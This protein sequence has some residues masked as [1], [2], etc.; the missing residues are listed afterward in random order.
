MVGVI[1][2]IV[3]VGIA[4]A[5]MYGVSG[6]KRPCPHC[7]TMMPKKST[8]CPHCHKAVRIGY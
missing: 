4:L 8:S 3:L 1:I 7:K 2:I 6:S 5:A